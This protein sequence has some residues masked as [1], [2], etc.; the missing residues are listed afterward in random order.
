M[1][2]IVVAVPRYF[3][4]SGE[5]DNYVIVYDIACGIQVFSSP[6]TIIADIYHLGALQFR[7]NEELIT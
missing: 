7:S 4:V 3:F 6:C 1:A 2:N 5:Y